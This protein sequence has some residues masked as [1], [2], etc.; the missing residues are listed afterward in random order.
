MCSGFG[1]ALPPHWGHSDIAA[2]YQTAGSNSPSLA[3][4]IERRRR[5]SSHA[6]PAM[7]W[8]GF[9]PVSHSSSRWLSPCGCP[10]IARTILPAHS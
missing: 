1:T 8:D 10:M 7:I 6:K 9:S 5:S 4:V 2:A 3:Q